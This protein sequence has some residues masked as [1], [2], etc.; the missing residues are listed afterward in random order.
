MKS[1]YTEAGVDI[2]KGNQIVKDIKGMVRSTFSPAVLA[3]IGLFGGLYDITGLGEGENVLVASIDGVGTKLHLAAQLNRFRGVGHDIVA[4]CCDDIVVQGARPLFFLDYV[5]AADLTVEG[6]T[7]IV[8]GIT[9]E[10]RTNHCALLGGETAEMPGTYCRGQY[11]LAGCIVGVV[12]RQKLIDGKT[13][14][15]GDVAVAL[16]S[17]GLH[18]NG[19][20]LARKI[21]FQDGGYD[22][23]YMPEAG[24]PTLGDILLEPHRSYIPTVLPLIDAIPVKGIAHI[25]GGGLYENVPRILPEGTG[26]T[27]DAKAFPVPFIY[28]FM[29]KLGEVDPKEMYRVFNMGIG[30][31]IFVSP[32]NAETVI[33]FAK[34]KQN[35]P[36]AVIGKVTEGDRKVE[37]VNL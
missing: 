5:A 35:L 13:I 16:P 22:L 27:F 37:I 11:D 19:F 26:V 28:Q 21:L 32:E 7:E 30:L 4:H 3:D 29:Q 18:T 23:S 25:T 14:K 15:P 6:V 33:R 36:A 17:S 34:E 8:A 2:D 10:C 12:N 31:V 9:E 1:K 20:S 24:G